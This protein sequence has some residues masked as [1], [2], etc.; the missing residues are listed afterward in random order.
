MKYCG[1]TFSGPKLYLCVPDHANPS[2]K[3]AHFLVW[4]ALFRSS[5][6][7]SLCTLILS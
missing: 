1:G 5:L 6:K 7:T 3:S 4:L 2:L